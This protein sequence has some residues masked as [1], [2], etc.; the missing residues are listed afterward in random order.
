VTVFPTHTLVLNKFPVT[1]MHVSVLRHWS[2]AFTLQTV[3]FTNN[4]E[5][6]TDYLSLS[7]FTCL[8]RWYVL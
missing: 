3:L 5:P 1:P 4:F 2:G 8:W 6:Q 7:D